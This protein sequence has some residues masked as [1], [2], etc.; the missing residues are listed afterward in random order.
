MFNKYL[1]AALALTLFPVF[2]SA[3]EDLAASC[4]EAAA[5]YSKN[6]IDGALEEARWCV[7]ALEQI[8]QKQVSESFPEEVA[9]YKGG[10]IRHQKAMGFSMIERDY[11]KGGEVISV[12]LNDSSKGGGMQG[13]AAIAQMGMMGGGKKFRIQR[14]EVMDMSEGER[15]EFMVSLK[16]GGMLRIESSN[17]SHANTLEFVKQ[18]PIAKLDDAL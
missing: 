2:V 4:N 16:S 14:R 7:E 10:D 13:I 17:V 3:S 9:G 12:S 8:K 6:D 11:R 5:L 1:P 18:F 15:V